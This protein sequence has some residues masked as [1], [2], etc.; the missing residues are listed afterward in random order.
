M[1]TVER[2]EHK[3]TKNPL[4][5]NGEHEMTNEQDRQVALRRV[6]VPADQ[7]P[8]ELT[9]GLPTVANQQQETAGLALLARRLDLN[10]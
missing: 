5:E 7:R 3:K 10:A 1:G 8:P 9:S 6:S 4:S 2:C